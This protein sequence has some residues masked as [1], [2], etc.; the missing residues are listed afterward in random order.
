VT[1][2][3]S[4]I[5]PHPMCQAAGG[6]TWLLLPVLLLFSLA[7]A[8]WAAAGAAL[9]LD[10]FND[11]A[12]GFPGFNMLS[13][14]TIEAWFRPAEPL[15]TGR[16]LIGAQT[17][18]GQNLVTV[19]STADRAWHVVYGPDLQ[20]IPYR[21]WVGTAGQTGSYSASQHH[22]ALTHSVLSL[23]QSRLQLYL[24]STLQAQ[25]HV[26][27][28]ALRAPPEPTL[29][30]LLG[31]CHDGGGMAEP[32]SG[33]GEREGQ[34]R[35]I[36]RARFFHG[37]LEEVRLWETV[38]A[39]EEIQESWKWTG[40]PLLWPPPSGDDGSSTGE[41][42]V[43]SRVAALRAQYSFDVTTSRIVDGS[44]NG[45]HGS[46]GSLGDMMD[47]PQYVPSPF[48]E[49]LQLGPIYL[50]LRANMS[51]TVE[52]PEAKFSFEASYNALLL[53]R[54][55]SGQHTTVHT[56]GGMHSQATA[57]QVGDFITTLS[58]DVLAS[59]VVESDSFTVQP[60][61][62]FLGQSPKLESCVGERLYEFVVSSTESTPP[63]AGPLFAVQLLREGGFVRLPPAPAN[64]I[65]EFWLQ[66]T[67]PLVK[68]STIFSIQEHDG[69]VVV[70]E[71]WREAVRLWLDPFH[72]GAV[73]EVCSNANGNAPASFRI[74]GVASALPQHLSLSFERQGG[75]PYW[76]YTV[77]IR[78]NCEVVLQGTVRKPC[79]GLD[80][81]QLWRPT[82]GQR[83]IQN[84]PGALGANEPWSAAFCA[85]YVADI[86][87]WNIPSSNLDSCTTMSS[88]LHGNETGLVAYFPVL[89]V[90][91]AAAAAD[92]TFVSLTS[93]LLKTSA[94]D[95]GGAV[96]GADVRCTWDDASCPD[97]PRGVGFAIRPSPFLTLPPEKVSLETT[98]RVTLETPLMAYDLD[99]REMLDSDQSYALVATSLEARA[100]PHGQDT[101]HFEILQV[102]NTRCGHIYERGESLRILEAEKR[103][104]YG[105]PPTTTIS[106]EG[107]PLR[108]VPFE[109]ATIAEE[110]AMNGVCST[111]LRYRA[112]DSYG[113]VSTHVA[114][115]GFRVWH[116]GVSL[117]LVNAS[118][119]NE[120][121]DGMDPGDMLRFL[122]DRPTNEPALDTR[123]LLDIVNGSW[124]SAAPRATWV[125]GGA[126]L[127]IKLDHGT[128]VGA[129]EIIPG[130]TCFRVR[131]AAGIQLKGDVLSLPCTD[132][133][134]PLGGDFGAAACA[135]GTV[136]NWSSGAC[137]ACPLGTL[138]F[139]EAGMPGCG[140]CPPG[141]FGNRSGALEC[142]PCVAGRYM[143]KGQGSLT[144]CLLA[145]AGTYVSWP[146][147]SRPEPCGPS[148]VAENEGSVEC[149]VCPD[150]AQCLSGSR[151]VARPGYIR[152]YA[153]AAVVAIEGTATRWPQLA[154][155]SA[156][157]TAFAFAAC[158]LS[159]ACL[160]ADTCA[161]GASQPSL[162]CYPCADG[163]TRLTG[164]LLDARSCTEC[165]E[166]WL[167]LLYAGLVLTGTMLFAVCLARLNIIAARRV[168]CL[169]SFMLKIGL[170][171]FFM[172]NAFVNVEEWEF[173]AAGFEHAT[174][175]FLRQ[176]F[177][178]VFAW[179]GAMP[180]HLIPVE[181][182]LGRVGLVA[183]S[184]R[185]FT[186]GIW[187]CLPLILV[188]LCLVFVVVFVEASH[189]CRCI[190]RCGKPPPPPHHSHAKAGRAMSRIEQAR[191]R[192][193]GVL[194]GPRNESSLPQSGCDPLE[195]RFCGIWRMS[196][197]TLPLRSRLFALVSDSTGIVIAALLLAYPPVLR[198]VVAFL[199]C[200]V[201]VGDSAGARLLMDPVI[202]CGSPEHSELAAAA[203][204]TL[205]IWGLGFPAASCL[206]LWRMRR[207][208]CDF[209]VRCRFGVVMAEYE[210]R[211][212]F[213]DVLIML[214]RFAIICAT[215]LNPAASRKLRLS[216]LLSVGLSCAVVH[217]VNE[218]FA[219]RCGLLLDVLEGQSLKIFCAMNVVLL[220]GFSGVAH[221][222][223]SVCLA[224]G[225]LTV[226]IAFILRLIM[227]FLMQVQRSV[228]D[229]L[230]ED[231]MLGRYEKGGLL[232]RVMLQFRERVFWLEATAQ[233]RRAYTT[234]DQASCILKVAPGLAGYLVRDHERVFV[235]QGLADCVEHAVNECKSE[236]LSVRFL[237]YLSRQAFAATSER[238]RSTD[239]VKQLL[240]TKFGGT[241]DSP[242]RKK[243]NGD[244]GDE[245]HSSGDSHI[246]KEDLLFDPRTFRL[247]MTA[248]DFQ[249]ELINI[250]TIS[251]HQLETDFHA[252]MVRKGFG[253]QYSMSP[254]ERRLS[255]IVAWGDRVSRL[256]GVGT[257]LLGISDGNPSSVSIMTFGVVP[258]SPTP[259]G[260]GMMQMEPLQ[261]LDIEDE[262]EERELPQPERV[263][264]CEMG[265]KLRLVAP[266]HSGWACDGRKEPQGCLSGITDYHQ[267]AGLRRFECRQC[268]F[269]LCE[270][271]HAARLAPIV[272]SGESTCLG[273][274]T[275][276]R[277]PGAVPADTSKGDT[278]LRAALGLGPV[279]VSQPAQ[280][281]QLMAVVREA[282]SGGELA[283]EAT[284]AVEE[285]VP[286][287]VETPMLDPTSSAGQAE[288]VL[289]TFKTLD[290]QKSDFAAHRSK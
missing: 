113:L 229:S 223:L 35:G 124:G 186:L 157:D 213:W 43:I 156:T 150:H 9:L 51:H 10:G 170:N 221:Y 78:R 142:Y 240:F 262:P 234:F 59:A 67:R 160:G 119:P 60:C 232:R 146:I 195:E 162:G 214:R 4:D 230:V 11:Y 286:P 283:T 264:C 56:P 121:D 118:D 277:L 268:N 111:E 72:G 27:S 259:Q 212:F 29:P 158:R 15:E 192:S 128:G 191:T 122:F 48:G 82:L 238:L 30:L 13:D 172:M 54:V 95:P 222:S 288:P 267:S 31:A 28:T 69:Q 161:I 207:R 137:N 61:R 270:R 279:G 64:A 243:R 159:V 90:D 257:S 287:C 66:L 201:L 107:L 244:R 184:R 263:C 85:M 246:T 74:P 93:G 58:L 5:R 98:A 41:A 266:T 225:A 104:E 99:G 21:A 133:S 154:L 140:P 62:G 3:A 290:F 193:T 7:R 42:A 94:N 210:P 100:P 245:D 175:Q 97:F 114:T 218:P 168:A 120:A 231:H 117:V 1:Q 151:A 180:A 265:H 143:P 241:G 167:G 164:S 284:R 185:W 20:E 258:I 187:A 17:F 273:D 131:R 149:A 255:T 139:S 276:A 198:Q 253:A 34:G 103:V 88:R 166:A 260:H 215:L 274:G 147:A 19:T 52:F 135:P 251:K 36:F 254:H 39:L 176:L 141:T 65:F 239:H 189:M 209:K 281:S 126:V 217:I 87:I 91:A 269:D 18:S 233:E 256:R 235:A 197:S 224:M 8:T 55:P 81:T 204:V 73:L 228:A 84:E 275:T 45:R 190:G 144:E 202:K 83:Y 200:D 109:G 123:D 249:S 129:P 6:G 23:Y 70:G 101:L 183:S 68:G 89:A 134:P 96:V 282:R 155:A 25:W 163:W 165:P 75:S 77:T 136:F 92:T 127:L 46:L 153:T 50:Q 26:D 178:I 116:P 105:L 22:L 80:S 181:C 44:G 145:P 76:S 169:H 86:R 132:I 271:C 194:D 102:P 208:L 53:V 16:C 226:H 171:H 188:L 237:E 112:I 205:A 38:R 71:P 125:E 37:Y 206:L 33:N 242:L 106:V 182:L 148:A 57:V 79:A 152:R 280:A 272:G 63:V 174:P 248:G 203:W 179:D 130:R 2:E 196:T 247:G 47:S 278:Q 289:R 49:A 220:F 40:R 173:K 216:L 227:N 108:F 24:N 14:W 285:E 177:G 261:V 110:E 32:V 236:R 211:F 219:N 199:R 250:T 115:V 138:W 12:T 252:F